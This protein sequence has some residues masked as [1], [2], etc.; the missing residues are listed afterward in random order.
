MHPD[1]RK[2]LEA[3]GFAP[4]VIAKAE[5]VLRAWG[6]ERLFAT[7]VYCGKPC[8][9]PGLPRRKDRKKLP[10]DLFHRYELGGWRDCDG[11]VICRPCDDFKFEYGW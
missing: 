2:Q 3:F 1:D 5:E 9:V 4:E 6:A 11:E 8:L 10:A 7:C